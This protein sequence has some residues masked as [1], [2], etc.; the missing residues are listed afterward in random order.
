MR[1]PKHPDCVAALCGEQ[2]CGKEGPCFILPSHWPAAN[3]E[4]R[5]SDCLAEGICDIVSEAMAG[6]DGCD[7]GGVVVLDD[8]ELLTMRMTCDLC[9]QRIAF[10][11]RLIALVN[12]FASLID[13]S[14]YSDRAINVWDAGSKTSNAAVLESPEQCQRVIAALGSANPAE[15]SAAI[16]ELLQLIATLQAQVV[17][18]DAQLT[19]PQDE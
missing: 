6:C 14:G 5:E 11:E 1:K 18:S 2:D 9:R 8:H 15:L 3:G 16:L 10:R 12:R 13:G 19:T 4:L 7:G 17:S